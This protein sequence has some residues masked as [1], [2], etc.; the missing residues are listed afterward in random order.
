MV[1]HSLMV[2]HVVLMG[3]FLGMWKAQDSVLPVSGVTDARSADDPVTLKWQGHAVIGS[4]VLHHI[5][6]PAS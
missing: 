2:Q 3:P 5:L 4:S 6:S 1:V